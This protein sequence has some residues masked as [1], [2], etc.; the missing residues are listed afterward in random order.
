VGEGSV[1]A[2]AGLNGHSEQY[3]LAAEMAVLGAMLMQPSVAAEVTEI[4]TAADYYR[5]GH[6]FIH[7]TIVGMLG[8]GEPVDTITVHARLE[9]D[10]TIS[11]IR[12]A[13][14]LHTLFAS[15]PT[16][17]NAAYHARIVRELADRR[18]LISFST[19]LG[20]Q[21]ANRGIDVGDV[22]EAIRRMAGTVAQNG[23]PAVPSLADRI[24]AGGCILDVPRTPEA[25]WGDGD[26]IFWALGQALIIAGPDGV[27]KTTLAGNLI[28][29]R[30]GAGAGD[31]LGL[32]VK[33]G[34]RNVLV[35]LM[36]R[37]QQAMTALARLFTDTDRDL[38]DAHL[39]VWRGPPPED[40]ARNTGLLS[41]LCA[42]ADAD[43]CIVDSL[44]DAVVKL[45]DDEAGS[46]WNRARQ[47]AIEAGTELVELHH[48][49]KRQDG[50]AKPA[51][52]DDL[53]GS[54]WI[55]AGAGSI[56]SLWGQAG[57]PI[58]DLSHLKP[59]TATVG[60]WQMTINGETGEVG[61]DRGVDLLAQ[62]RLRGANGM[63][64]AV[65]AR[66][67]T[68]SEKPTPNELARARRWL[69][70]KVDSGFLVRRDGT[71]GGGPN[72][73]ETTWFLAA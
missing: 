34:G 51:T 2:L 14:Y 46:G 19:S 8:R 13:D 7:E 17:A 67:I 24:L 5:P 72:R 31:V 30:L 25:V 21:A 43:T 59:V 15:V 64:A 70:K 32:P 62:I 44:K 35:L 36:D 73:V 68:S 58:I 23:G 12:G 53:Y 63:T 54:R 38:L 10:G 26:D 29:A 45:T 60:P 50:N 41:Q 57:D 9:A 27:G 65:A 55:P 69:N 42:L 49:R 39:R 28:R 71:W 56:I 11:R 4:L 6:Q 48:P 61:V 1:T 66:L 16:A 33:P 20:Q 47:L 40:L 37:P 22:H 52:I 3:D 18:K